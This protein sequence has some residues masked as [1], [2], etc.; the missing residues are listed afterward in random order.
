MTLA[1]D[2]SV[3]ANNVIENGGLS[4]G[5]KGSRASGNSVRGT[6][7]LGFWGSATGNV[8]RVTNQVAIS[9]IVP[10][11][12]ISGNACLD[13]FNIH[14]D[15][16]SQRFYATGTSCTFYT[17]GDMDNF[18]PGYCV[19]FQSS[20]D[21]ETRMITGVSGNTI[22]WADALNSSYGGSSNQAWAYTNLAHIDG[23]SSLSVVT[24]NFVCGDINVTGGTNLSCNFVGSSCAITGNRVLGM[25]V[26]T[27]EA[28]KN[29]VIGNI[30]TNS[31]A[32][33]PGWPKVYPFVGVPDNTNE[34]AHNIINGSVV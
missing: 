17:A 6:L 10:R 27:A 19:T 5:G 28:K 18:Q 12:Q 16:G 29:V 33:Q 7:T 4:V 15:T 2:Y 14:S 22:S 8:I 31:K 26:T 30:F 9:A 25:M 32:V 1:G 11:A 23:V 13:E 21:I 24:G 3:A 20:K 34:I